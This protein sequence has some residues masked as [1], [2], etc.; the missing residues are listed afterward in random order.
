MIGA[1][2]IAELDRSQNLNTTPIDITGLQGDVYDYTLIAFF[3]SESSGTALNLTFNNDSGTNYRFYVM[4]GDSATA[5]AQ[6][7]NTT[8]AT[9]ESYAYSYPSFLLVNISGES[10]GERKISGQ[11]SLSSASG[12]TKV[13]VLDSYWKN[14]ANEITSIQLSKGAS[15]TSTFHI[16]V[17]RVPKES[18]QGSWEYMKELSWSSETAEKSFTGLDG[19]T[20]IQYMLQWDGDQGMGVQCNNDGGSNYP[21]QYL[22]N[23]GGTINAGNFASQVTVFTASTQ[24]TYIIN[25]ESGVDRLIYGSGSGDYGSGVDQAQTCNWWQNKP[26]NLTS[27]DLTPGASATGTCKLYRKINPNT[28]SDPLPFETIKVF[29]VSGDYSAG[30]TLSGLTCDDYKMIKIEWLGSNST[31]TGAIIGVR[32][33]SDTGSNY[34]R[35]YLRARGSTASAASSTVTSNSVAFNDDGTQNYGVIYIYPKSGEYR[36]SL[37]R[38][39]GSSGT[40]EELWFFAQWWKNSVDEIISITTFSSSTDSL[41]GQIKISVLR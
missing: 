20:D 9:L 41:S 39:L 21:K 18:I 14:T 23:T 40:V 16:M 30:D 12:D 4:T 27:L 22:R 10:G 38:T 8:T 17:Y 34:D 31:T 24:S 3:E 29:D 13:R 6:A 28:T 26:D 32:F 2:L 11:L 35:Q 15:I 36:P 37:M 25:A 1:E 5:N 19:D 7:L 33:N